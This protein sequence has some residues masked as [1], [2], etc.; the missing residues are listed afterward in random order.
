MAKHKGK[1]ALCG[2]EGKLTFEHIPPRAAFNSKPVR[3]VT[4]EAILEGPD[5]EPWDIS[6]LKYINQ[7]QGMGL[8]SLCASCNNDTGAWYGDAYRD[9]A[10]RGMLLVQNDIDPAY[11]SVGFQK[12][13]P[14]RFIKQVLSLFCSV[15]PNANIDDLRAFVRDRDATGLDKAKYKVCMYFTRSQT[16]R[17]F[18]LAG[19]GSFTGEVV[20]FSEITAAPFG[21]LLYL[22]PPEK[23]DF[24]GFDI[25]SFADL[26]YDD[27]HDVKMPLVF[28]EVNNW[29]PHDYRSKDEIR[30]AYTQAQKAYDLKE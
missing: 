30:T 25:T 28:R 4:L 7:Q 27:L 17:Y 26:K 5:R 8:H 13:Y 18:G 12:V 14:L 15:N 29:L 21:F 11:Q 20:V 23:Y 2:K 19:M 9:F 6:G 10:H 1:C 16:K 22:N 24:A 3:P